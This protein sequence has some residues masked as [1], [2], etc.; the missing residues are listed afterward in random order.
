[1]ID[2][3]GN[4]HDGQLVGD[5]VRIQS[6]LPDAPELRTR[7]DFY[8]A[9]LESLELG[10]SVQR[11]KPS[12][13]TDVLYITA[14]RVPQNTVW[15]VPSIPVTIEIRDE[16]NQLLFTRQS[17]TGKGVEWKI[18]DE[19]VGTLKILATSIDARG[20][21]HGGEYTL[22]AHSTTPLTPRVGHW[23]TIDVTDG[24]GGT[25]ITS[26][27]QDRNGVIWFGLYQAGLCR[28]DGRQFQTFT[29]ADGLP[30][31]NIHT[32]FEDHNGVLWLG[33]KDLHRN[34]SGAGVCRY[35]GVTFKTFTTKDGLVDNSVMAIYEDKRRHLWFGTT[36]GVSEFD[37]ETF[38]NYT[39][40]DGLLSNWVGAITQD[41][42]GNLWFGY[43]MKYWHLLATGATR[44]DGKTF[45][46]FRPPAG[47]VATVA[48][49][50]TDADGNLWFAGK[51]GVSVY[52]GKSFEN[53]MIAK[54]G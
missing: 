44:Y 14:L 21:T 32:V 3:T 2:I 39:T 15:T 46:H 51:G 20:E 48:S 4:G 13:F 49:M 27:A 50:T 28:Y 26:I 9:Y 31:N 11:H 29:T 22:K 54:G 19:V 33:T 40:A 43:G 53:F 16:A 18:P 35:D 5:A 37:G 38:K 30:S 23:E 17:R 47:P 8:Q 24:L 6:K 45:T 36:G 25:V 52:D 34:D 42:D 12:E 10:L 41:T 7:A 1:M